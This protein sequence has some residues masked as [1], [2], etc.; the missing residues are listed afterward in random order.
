[1][2]MGI[3]D[4]RDGSSRIGKGVNLTQSRRPHSSRPGRS[5][6]LK[7]RT[8]SIGRRAWRIWYQERWTERPLRCLCVGSWALWRSCDRVILSGSKDAS[9]LGGI[10]KRTTA[11]LFCAWF[12]T[13]GLICSN[14]NLNISLEGLISR[15]KFRPDK[16]SLPDRFW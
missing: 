6:T 10:A 7:L 15:H 9:A 14:R 1:M 12:V 16:Y 2:A 3:R 5:K 11:Y 13:G 8:W 4:W